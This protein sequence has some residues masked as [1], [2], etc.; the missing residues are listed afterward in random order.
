M[1]RNNNLPKLHK[2]VV[3][4]VWLWPLGFVADGRI[5]HCENSDILWPKVI[6]V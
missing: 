4:S 1:Q 5:L 2:A 6:S 3:E